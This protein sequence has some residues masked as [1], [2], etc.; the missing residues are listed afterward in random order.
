MCFSI[1]ITDDLSTTKKSVILVVD[2]TLKLLEFW[3]NLLLYQGLTQE[4]RAAKTVSSSGRRRRWKSLATGSTNSRISP[5]SRKNSLPRLTKCRSSLKTS[6]RPC[7]RPLNLTLIVYQMFRLKQCR[8]RK[9]SCSVPLVVQKHVICHL[10]PYNCLVSRCKSKKWLG[11]Q[12]KK[13]SEKNL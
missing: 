1:K 10:C 12:D 8:N 5:S 4:F 11:A 7:E 3:A 13:P 9:A 2:C 6:L